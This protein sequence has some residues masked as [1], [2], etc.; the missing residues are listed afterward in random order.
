MILCEE[1]LS[2]VWMV[3]SYS[4]HDV[5]L[6][7]NQA[8]IDSVELRLP[9]QT[10]LHRRNPFS[11]LAEARESAKNFAGCEALGEMVRLDLMGAAFVRIP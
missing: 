8:Q 2:L 7:A 3:G 1:L 10:S 4:E 11:D 9:K 5:F 6:A